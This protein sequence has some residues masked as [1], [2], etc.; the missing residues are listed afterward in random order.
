MRLIQG[1]I[2]LVLLLVSMAAKAE[3]AGM[4]GC[5]DY[6][7]TPAE[8]I[9]ACTAALAE[10]EAD[11]LQRARL[12]AGRAWAHHERAEYAEAEADFTAA[13][14]DA[15]FMQRLMASVLGASGDAESADR[16]V[17]FGGAFLGRAWSRITLGKVDEGIADAEI[18][19]KWLQS[20]TWDSEAIM[21][22]AFA[23]RLRGDLVA[24]EERYKEGL[25]TDPDN[26]YARLVYA[27]MLFDLDRDAEAMPLLRQSVQGDASRG[28]A[29]FWL[30][31]RSEDPN[32]RGRTLDDYLVDAQ[33][34]PE[35][36]GRYYLGT[37]SA[38]ELLREAEDVTPM[39]TRENLCE[40]NFYIAEALRVAG[41]PDVARPYYQAV[42]DTGVVWYIEYES[43]QHWLAKN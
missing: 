21:A 12:Y 16:S 4:A 31:I 5:A 2:L 38:N 26:A 19:G 10:P 25:E 24:A 1:L 27:S 39:K 13:V 36:I 22:V 11:T 29:N 8:R 42:V 32:E 9:E 33:D 18:A 37:I 41:K 28:Y 20:Q 17:P 23:E 7:S 6:D 43:A 15:T 34:W 35:P 30:F 14:A 40:A 3:E